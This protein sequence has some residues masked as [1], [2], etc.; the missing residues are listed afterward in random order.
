MKSSIRICAVAAVA[1]ASLAGIISFAH[2]ATTESMDTRKPAL[3]ARGLLETVFNQRKVQEGFDKYVGATYTQHNPYAADGKQ[4]AID[5]L[6][7]Y[8]GTGAEY[9]YDIKHIYVDGR[10]VVVHSHVTRG[11]DD[12]GS[13][14]IDIFRL[15]DGDRIVEHWDVLQPIPEKSANDNTMF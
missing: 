13:A 4:A 10:I 3:V 11:K 5:F 8:L 6:S 1:A 7:K 9:K 14:V 2:T 15:D 12:R